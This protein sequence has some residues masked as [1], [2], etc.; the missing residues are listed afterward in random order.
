VETIYLRR[1]WP[2]F[3][4]MTRIFSFL[5]RGPR[6][7]YPPGSGPPAELSD[8]ELC[9]DTF[10]LVRGLVQDTGGNLIQRS[11]GQ[12]VYGDPGFGHPLA[13][14]VPHHVLTLLTLA[15][16][17]AG[18]AVGG[19]G[20]W[21]STV[22][23]AQLRHLYETFALVS[24]LLD[25][26]EA[27][28]RSRGYGLTAD[29]IDLLRREGMQWEQL[30]SRDPSAAVYARRYAAAA[31]TML[32]DLQGLA[33]STGVPIGEKPNRSQL[34]TRY[35][36]D[37]GGYPAFAALSNAGAHPSALQP[38]LFY[39]DVRTGAMEFDFQGKNVERAYWMACCGECFRLLLDL[40][41]PVLGWADWP[42]LSL[43]RRTALDGLRQEAD[44][45][46][47]LARGAFPEVVH[48]Q[49]PL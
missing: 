34:M 7:G 13:T 12:G 2:L 15:A 11:Y 23:L 30:A 10:E 16:D 35:L 38:V 46:Y 33:V 48:E 47:A 19:L 36:P 4:A 29:A 22:A 21:A 20:G 28:Q 9:R 5:G 17:A 49:H 6:P 25:G 32:R 39:S 42:R 31:A 37:L 24:W 44:R 40:A 8:Q 27:E 1:G 43:Q 3:N 45:R 41:G 18:V 26:D 14:Q